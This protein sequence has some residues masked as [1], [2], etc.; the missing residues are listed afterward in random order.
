MTAAALA[1]LLALPSA[2]ADTPG[3]RL[4]AL[5]RARFIAAAV[6]LPTDLEKWR[7]SSARWGTAD[8]DFPGALAAAE[9]LEAL[10]RGLVAGDPE[11]LE[12]G[13]RELAAAFDIG[14]PGDDALAARYEAL[15]LSLSQGGVTLEPETGRMRGADGGPLDEKDW[16]A[17][18]EKLPLE[19][20][21]RLVTVF[22]AGAGIGAEPPKDPLAYVPKKKAAKAVAKAPAAAAPPKAA[23]PKAAAPAS[24]APKAAPAG[25]KA[26]AVAKEVERLQAALE[27][28]GPNLPAPDRAVLFAAWRKALDA[29]VSE[30]GKVDYP[31]AVNAFA[32]LAAASGTWTPAGRWG[33][34]AAAAYNLGSDLGPRAAMV[35]AF[36]R[37][38]GG[39][40]A[41]HLI[42]KAMALTGAAAAPKD[43][44]GL[45]AAIKDATAV[46]SAA[47]GWAGALPNAKKA[48]PI[49]GTVKTFKLEGAVG[50]L[51]GLFGL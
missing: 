14:Q 10:R 2:A 18:L 45:G 23:G 38:G 34:T 22:G 13:V 40:S 4:A 32:E 39:V 41:E 42:T 31:L 7:E 15:R 50:R 44:K 21:R 47:A 28:P 1:F 35:A 19:A 6:L 9:G 26:D 48:D 12:D 11:A 20:R 17:H 29:A 27:L 37:N 3:T 8:P 43:Q 16:K 30:E 24:A 49:R 5:T 33:R 46:E 36:A 25:P 51:R